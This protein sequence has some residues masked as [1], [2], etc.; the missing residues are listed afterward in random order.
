MT[1][2]INTENNGHDFPRVAYKLIAVTGMIDT[3]EAARTLTGDAFSGL[4]FIVQEAIKALRSMEG[5]AEFIAEMSAYKLSALAGLLDT[6]ERAAELGHDTWS[7]IRIIMEEVIA[8]LFDGDTLA[9]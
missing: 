4:C 9:A 1:T 7:G 8:A 3:P 2:T 6:V 5:E